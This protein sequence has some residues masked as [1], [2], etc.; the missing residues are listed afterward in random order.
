MPSPAARHWSMKPTLVCKQPL[1]AHAQIMPTAQD[2]RRRAAVLTAP[3]RGGLPVAPAITRTAQ[4]NSRID[5]RL[6]HARRLLAAGLDWSGEGVLGGRTSQCLK[7]TSVMTKISLPRSARTLWRSGLVVA[8]VAALPLVISKSAAQADVARVMTPSAPP[9]TYPQ[10]V[11]ADQPSVYYRLGEK[12]G[13][14]AADSSPHDVDGT[15]GADA[16]MGV[17]GAIAGDSNAAVAGSN[18][19]VVTAPAASLPAG[20]SART[21][22]IWYRASDLSA[23][24]WPM[25]SYGGSQGVGLRFDVGD[26]SAHLEIDGGTNP[27]IFNLPYDDGLWHLYDVTFTG[28]VVTGFADGQAIGSAPLTLGTSVARTTLAIGGGTGSFDEA[29]IYPSALT[30]AKIDAHWTR[31]ESS[32]VTCA[33]APSGRYAAAIRADAPLVY[34]RLGD[35]SRLM[36]DSSGHCANAA[37]VSD[38]ATS[39]PGA[40]AGDPNA[41]VTG[42]GTVAIASASSLPAGKSARTL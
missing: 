34:Y 26:G 20:D 7:G 5:P 12:S 1:T 8:V 6:D 37:R 23:N 15:Y 28:S 4:P 38:D 33:G 25:I 35:R 17:A 29:A 36:L 42:D 41:G 10:E 40:I 2:R 14:V 24:S 11:L 21:V 30:P 39:V 32:T 27:V 18:A 9:K 31:A 19:A 22:E 16:T 13:S 3:R